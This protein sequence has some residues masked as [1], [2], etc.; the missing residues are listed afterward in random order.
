[1]IYWTIFYTGFARHIDSSGWGA[2]VVGEGLIPR[3]PVIFY[4]LNG[5]TGPPTARTRKEKILFGFME[6]IPWARHGPQKNE[7]SFISWAWTARA[8]VINYL[9]STVFNQRSSRAPSVNL[10]PLGHTKIE[11]EVNDCSIPACPVRLV[12]AIGSIQRDASEYK[13][14]LSSHLDKKSL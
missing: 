4:S 2:C 11:V 1:M 7:P 5:D 13:M 3:G 12:K 6:S 14:P 8:F 10:G 9:I